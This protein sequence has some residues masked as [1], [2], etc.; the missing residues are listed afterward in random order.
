MRH[1]KINNEIWY[2]DEMIEDSAPECDVLKGV[3]Y[4]K[5]EFIIDNDDLGYWYVD[6]DGGQGPFYSLLTEDWVL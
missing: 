4:Y 6:Q 3:S 1:G 5:D 2:H